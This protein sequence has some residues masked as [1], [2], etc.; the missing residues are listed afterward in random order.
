MLSVEHVPVLVVFCWTK[1]SLSP[2][3]KV[4]WSAAAAQPPFWEIDAAAA[5]LHIQAF[6]LLLFTGKL[7]EKCSKRWLGV[8][9]SP[10]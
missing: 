1:G 9:S 5:R 3:W 6:H 4:A 10:P 8:W 2:L 7:E